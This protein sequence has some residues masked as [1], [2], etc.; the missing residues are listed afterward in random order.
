MTDNLDWSTD[1]VVQFENAVLPVLWQGQTMICDAMVEK[2][3]GSAYRPA[4]LGTFDTAIDMLRKRGKNMLVARDI[5]ADLV[6][7]QPLALAAKN[8]VTLRHTLE[9][10]LFTSISPATAA[11][12]LAQ[13]KDQVTPAVDAALNT[14]RKI[15]ISHALARQHAYAVQAQE[16]IQR[17]DK[18]SKQIFF[19]SIN[20]G[21]EA[22]RVG[23]AGRGFTQISTDIR[24][25][26]QSAQAATRI[27]SE[28][29][30]GA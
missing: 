28:L 21:V 5:R 13:I 24:A 18:I 3:D 27:L 1:P 26:S 29:V 16:A 30:Q 10:E 25:L 4:A 12:L 19:I 23:D 7:L 11:T 20:A 15:F 2:P 6:D 17:L 22:A 9:A 14:Y 8:I